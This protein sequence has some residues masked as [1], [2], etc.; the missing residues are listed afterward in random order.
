MHIRCADIREARRRAS[1]TA[2]VSPVG[3][4]RS[5]SMVVVGSDGSMDNAE[6]VDRAAG[7]D[8]LD[9]LGVA[10]VVERPVLC[11]AL[12]RAFAV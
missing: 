10:Y 11:G 6:D 8:D 2:S 4:P 9:R 12:E 1:T 3:T 5:R 7:V